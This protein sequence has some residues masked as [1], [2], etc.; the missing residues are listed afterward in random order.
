MGLLIYFGGEIIADCGHKTKRKG[1]I[2]AHGESTIACLPI[3][4]GKT[5]YCLR[6]IEEMAIKCAW[7]GKVIFVG[8]PVTLYVLLD[9]NSTPAEHAIIYKDNPLRLVGCLRQECVRTGFG[10]RAGIWSA[11]GRVQRI[12]TP[13]E[14]Y[15]KD[16]QDEKNCS[17]IIGDLR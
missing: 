4:K 2:T 9:K 10:V 1:L 14:I 7:C 8:D 13:Y 17:V 12:L 3:N 15:M 6:C 16:M 11:P 5:P